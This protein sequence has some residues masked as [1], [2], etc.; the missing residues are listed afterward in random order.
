MAR[1]EVEGSLLV[2]AIPKANPRTSSGIFP[3]ESWHWSGNS[4]QKSQ[5]VGMTR[6]YYGCY[7]SSPVTNRN[8][9][10]SSV[11]LVSQLGLGLQFLENTLYSLLLISPPRNTHHVNPSL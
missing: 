4:S 9:M 10:R 5:D 1:G 7:F 11:L 6:L 8:E 2:E 3:Q